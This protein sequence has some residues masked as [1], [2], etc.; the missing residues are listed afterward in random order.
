VDGT[1]TRT[2]GRIVPDMRQEAI[3][4]VNV[5]RAHTRATGQFGWRK[6]ALTLEPVS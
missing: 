5:F 3:R 1:E 2:T 6:Q 4:F